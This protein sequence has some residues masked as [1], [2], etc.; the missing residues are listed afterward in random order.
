MN[1]PV[2]T[3]VQGT[4][5][6]LISIPHA[7][8]AIPPGQLERMTPEARFLDD[9]DW[10]VPD[11][12]AFARD[13]GA[14]VLVAQYSRYV[15]DL[16]RPRDDQSLYPGQSTTGLCPR[17][18]FAE[19]PLYPQGAEPTAAEVAQRVEDYWVPYHRALVGEVE[20]L[21]SMHPNVCL[22][23]AHSIASVVPR[24]FD[25]RLPDFNIGTNSGASCAPGL[26]ERLLAEAGTFPGATSVLN[27]RF[28]G[29]AI[30][31]TY[32]APDRGI[33]AVQLELAQSTYLVE[34]RPYPWNP[35]RAPAAQ[36]ALAQLVTSA[37]AFLRAK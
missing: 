33:H 16:N 5:P 21:R 28:K 25:G 6:L 31:R 36:K 13:L 26:G 24:F 19:V 4:V 22:W 15:V 30:T 37:L 23:D 27:G 3:L 8:T 10:H 18:T 35:E 12:Y 34:G 29:G 32:G 9:T 14:S 20:R 7:G 17:D 2:F 11:L 1:P